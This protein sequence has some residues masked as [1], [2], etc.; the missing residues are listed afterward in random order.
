MSE[1]PSRRGVIVPSVTTAIIVLATLSLGVWQLERR[2]DKLALIATLEERLSAEPVWL[3]RSET[4]SELSQ[5]KDEF[6][7]VKILGSIE[8]GREARVYASGS[9]LRKDVTGPGTWVFAPAYVSGSGSDA[10]VV[11]NRGFV[12]DGAESPASPYREPIMLTGYIRFA[13]EP[14]WF[15]PPADVAKRLWFLR[16]HLAMSRALGWATGARMAPFYIDLETPV[17][18]GGLP[19]PG[20]LQVNLKN[21]HLQYAITWF[22]LAIA[23]SVSFG[24]WLRGQLRRPSG[25]LV[26]PESSE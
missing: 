8:P 21:D 22:L 15:T 26:K 23:V 11:V 2:A 12:P 1:A 10:K 3:P 5:A 9:P 25:V 19:K 16:D 13:E 6:R 18:P 17:P 14:G 24:I 20:P 7:R 4:W